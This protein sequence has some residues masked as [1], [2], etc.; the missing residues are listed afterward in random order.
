LGTVAAAVARTASL[1]FFAAAWY[2]QPMGRRRMLGRDELS[3]N[4]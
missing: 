3:A 1:V 4:S 2:C